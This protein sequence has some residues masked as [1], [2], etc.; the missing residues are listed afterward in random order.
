MLWLCVPIGAPLPLLMQVMEASSKH[1][2]LLSASWQVAMLV[3]IPAAL[4]AERLNRRKYF[5]AAVN[6]PH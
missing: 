4:W 2:G 3:Q 6:I 5:W 1:L